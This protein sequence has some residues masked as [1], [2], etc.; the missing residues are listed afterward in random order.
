MRCKCESHTQDI[1]FLF[2]LASYVVPKAVWWLYIYIFFFCINMKTKCWW[3]YK[4]YYY[5]SV[6]FTWVYCALNTTSSD[7]SLLFGSSCRA[8][9]NVWSIKGGRI[10]KKYLG[11]KH[12]K[13]NKL[14]TKNW[15]QTTK[16]KVIYSAIQ[17]KPQASKILLRSTIGQLYSCPWWVCYFVNPELN[18]DRYLEDN[19]SKQGKKF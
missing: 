10:E 4:P 14:Y 17:Q 8:R 11:V 18:Y 5:C 12:K 3:L 2:S 6:V 7:W 16:N 9:I 19:W 1:S 13:I 15:V